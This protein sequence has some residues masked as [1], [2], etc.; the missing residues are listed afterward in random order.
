[1]AQGNSITTQSQAVTGL[2]R[3]TDADLEQSRVRTKHSS[4]FPGLVYGIGMAA[5][6]GES[7][8]ADAQAY[9]KDVIARMQPRDAL[10]EMLIAQL[11][12]THSRVTRLAYLANQQEYVKDIAIINEYADRATNTYRRQMLAL[13]EYRKPPRQGDTIAFVN[14]ANIAGQQVVQNGGQANE[15]STNEQ[16]C[17]AFSGSQRRGE[18]P[19]EGIPTVG[20]RV[21]VASGLSVASEAMDEGVRAADGCRETSLKSECVE[22][23]R[24]K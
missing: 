10:E 11:L 6:L 21:G 24:A 7:G 16:G 4:T 20:E 3:A 9:A 15:K 22:A 18:L 13:A 1:M 12:Y 23:R 8:K 17:G 19:A 5:V 14:Q 2:N